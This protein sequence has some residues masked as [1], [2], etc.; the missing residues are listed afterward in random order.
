MNTGS[1]IENV[2]AEGLIIEVVIIV[3]VYKAD[4]Q[5]FGIAGV[6]D[7][8]DKVY[9]IAEFED[10]LDWVDGLLELLMMLIYIR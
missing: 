4:D 1:I 5:V 6:H 7:G 3:V 9:E 8:L 10:E 2:D